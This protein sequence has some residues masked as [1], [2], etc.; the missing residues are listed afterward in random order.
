P[1]GYSSMEEFRAKGLSELG[2]ELFSRSMIEIQQHTLDLEFMVSGFDQNSGNADIFT[3]RSRGDVS[4]YSEIGFWAIG[5]GQTSA[6]GSL[7]NSELRVRFMDLPSCLYRVLEAK[8]NAETATGVGQN[9]IASILE[10]D[11]TRYAVDMSA[12][13]EIKEMWKQT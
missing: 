12:I 4:Y 9:T 13:H 7:F 5:S 6:L 3:V 11:G 2:P 10:S 8:F 1:L